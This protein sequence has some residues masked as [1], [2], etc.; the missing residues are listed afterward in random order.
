M[1]A[2]LWSARGFFWGLA[3]IGL[4]FM[5]SRLLSLKGIPALRGF[6]IYSPFSCCWR[7]FPPISRCMRLIRGQGA[8]VRCRSHLCSSPDRHRQA[9]NSSC[10]SW[11][12]GHR[13]PPRTIACADCY[14]GLH[15]LARHHKPYWRWLWALALAS[16][17]L[18]FV[19]A[20]HPLP[21]PASL[22]RSP[23]GM[24][25]PYSDFF[26]RGVPLLTVRWEVLLVVGMLFLSLVLRLN[27][28]ENLPGI[29]GDEGERGMNA[30]AINE[31]S[32]AD[33]FGYG[34]W[35]VPN[36][37]F[38]LVSIMLRV[39]GDNM[40]GDR[41]L[42]VMSGAGHQETPRARRTRLLAA[43]RG[44]RSRPRASR[45][46]RVRQHRPRRLGAACRRGGDRAAVAGTQL[47][48]EPGRAIPLPRPRRDPDHDSRP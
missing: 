38:Y 5:A 45:D 10:S 14:L 18:S 27:N 24:P 30:R 17:L 39:F 25:G 40:A 32:R 13:S 37:Y 21:L 7:P 3:A 28:L 41:M 22:T 29:F 12:D 46:R 43:A 2:R 23:K 8:A 42:S 15:A 11:L 35:S 47:G 6:V 48:G 44:S 16:L 9:C 33:I 31:G 26:A 34:W 1:S 19:G 4:A 20:P 36:L